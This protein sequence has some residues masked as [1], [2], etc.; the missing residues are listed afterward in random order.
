MTSMSET[1]ESGE[2]TELR[3]HF[4]RRQRECQAEKEAYET[5]LGLLTP[6]RWFT[7]IG[8][9]ILSAAAGAIVLLA[10]YRP[11]HEEWR[12]YAAMSA[13]VASMLTGLHTG[14]DCDVHQAECRRLAQV[15]SGLETAYES[16]P[17]GT[18]ERQRLRFE[19]LETKL[20]EAKSEAAATPPRWCRSARP[21]LS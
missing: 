10:E 16:A 8:G 14:L 11:G 19:Q 7:V 4:R 18:D 17:L 20:Q 3:E 1:I 5:W 15:Y 9:I 6:L 12:L 13:I 2:R 21:V